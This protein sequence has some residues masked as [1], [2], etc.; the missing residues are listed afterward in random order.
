MSVDS[1]AYRHWSRELRPPWMAVWS[2]AMAGLRLIFRRKLFWALFAL[3]SVDFLFVFATIYLKAQISAEN[4]AI[5]EFVNHVLT[6]VTGTGET[7]QDFMFAQGTVTM[8][9][10]A[11]AG[12]MLVGSDFRHGGLTFFLSR[13]IGRRHYIAGKL[14]TVAL[15]VSLTTTLPALVL[16]FEYA[17][18]TDSWTYLR[19]NAGILFGI[20]GYGAIMAAT[21]SLLLF[22]MASWLQKTAPLVM[23]WACLFILLPACAVILREVFD[24]DGWELLIL[25]R[26]IRQVGAWCFGEGDASPWSWAGLIVVGVSF[27]SVSAAIPRVRAVRVIA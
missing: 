11:F 16:Y 6:S 14:L 22:A 15:L 25:W 10:L 26:D 8:L 4:P 19:E 12:E 7:Y 5:A 1:S 18:L 2:V 17:L 23:C 13:R 3:A 20:L 21:L 24:H 27:I 9:L